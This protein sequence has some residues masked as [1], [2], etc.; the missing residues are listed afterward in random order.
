M[1]NKIKIK[2]SNTEKQNTIIDYKL[3]N[4]KNKIFDIYKM[5]SIPFS[6]RDNLTAKNVL[7]QFR[8]GNKLIV[9]FY[10]DINGRVRERKI[11]FDSRLHLDLMRQG[12]LS[13]EGT[14]FLRREG[15]LYDR[16]KYKTNKSFED[17]KFYGDDLGVN[18]AKLDKTI[19]YTKM[20]KFNNFVNW[21][22]NCKTKNLREFYYCINKANE[23]KANG[24]GYITLYF[25]YLDGSEGK[26]QYKSKNIRGIT[27][28]TDYLD[29][30]NL[31]I[32]RILEIRKG[33]VAGSDMM[34]DNALELM[35]D[36]FDVKYIEG[37]VE[38]REECLFEVVGM[39]LK[40]DKKNLSLKSCGI[41]TFN[42]LYY[43]K[44][45]TDGDS[46]DNIDKYN[47]LDKMKYQLNIN[48]I[49]VRI[50]GNT[51]KI[52]KQ[53]FDKIK[54]SKADINING[55]LKGRRWKI[56]N[57]MFQETE[58][59]LE[60]Y[61]D[62]KPEFT[63]IYDSVNKH[64]DVIKG[65]SIMTNK[66]YN[67]ILK[68][69]V[70]IDRKRNIYLS[71]IT[72]DGKIKMKKILTPSQSIE[73]AFKIKKAKHKFIF[74]DYETI[75]DF[76]ELSV[77]KPY[78][79]SIFVCDQQEMDELD[80][81]DFEG[82]K[83]SVQEIIKNNCDNFV[84]FDCS[85]KLFNYIRQ[86]QEDTIF[87]LVSFNGAN[88]DNF[89]LA[90][91]LYKNQMES[92]SNVCY[93]NNQ[94]L[95]FK[96]NRRHNTFD[97]A[98][99]L[100]GSLKKNCK[101]FKIKC[102]SKKD[103]DHNEI[104]SIYENDK[105]G[106]INKMKQNEEM[107]IYNNYD[108]VSLAVLYNRY[109]K[110]FG[111]S[112]YTQHIDL[113]QKL[114]IGSII[115]EVFDKYNSNKNLPKLDYEDYKAIL[116]HK[117]AGRVELFNGVQKIE[118]RLSSYDV[119]SL[120]PFICSVYKCYFPVG[121]VIK[122]SWNEFNDFRNQEGDNVKIIKAFEEE[123][124]EFEQYEI[125]EW[126][127]MKK[128]KGQ[129]WDDIK[130][131]IINIERGDTSFTDKKTRYTITFDKKTTPNKNH[132]GFFWVNVNQSNLIKKNLPLIYAKKIYDKRG[133]L[134]KNDW[135]N[136][137]LENVFLSSVI[138]DAL[139]KYGCDVE[140]IDKKGLYFSGVVKNY[141]LFGFLRDFMK[142]KNDQD[143][144]RDTPEY[145]SALRETLKLLM[146]AIS[147]K[148]IEGLHYDKIKLVNEYDY[149]KI[150]NDKK[151]SKINTIDMKGNKIFISYSID[152]EELIKKQRP[153]YLGALIYDYAKMYM[154]NHIYSKIGLENL[155]YTD[156]DAG[157]CRDKHGQ[158]WI[159][160]YAGKKEMKDL[161]WSDIYD[162]DERY[163]THKLYEKGSKVFGSF[164]NELTDKNIRSYVLMKKTYM[165]INHD[166]TLDAFHFK[167]VS[168]SNIYLTGKE[169]FIE[170]KKIKHKDGSIENKYIIKSQLGA[171]DFYYKSNDVLVK[172]ETR[173]I[174]GKDKKVMVNVKGEQVFK[175]ILN[176]GYALVL[177]M[178]FRK[179]FKNTRQNVGIDD[180]DKFNKMNSNIKQVFQIKKLRLC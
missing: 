166:G 62:K 160:K 30:H 28:D 21:R 157:K 73:N 3:N 145:N 107:I 74:F 91:Y 90:E 58:G 8:E 106:F 24:D 126:I 104:Q 40:T 89:L 111:N 128:E 180:D 133:N 13:T 168:K 54:K 118:E 163:K 53:T 72:E 132:I 114:T 165:I 26:Y 4:Q 50:I 98:K 125:E 33:E 66:I 1:N 65:D 108:V 71:S 161:I 56:S 18:G 172:Y 20:D 43:L 154:Y 7:N 138:I 75:T 32:E 141:E 16:A 80:K 159:N 81:A 22:V 86:N 129:L 55:T 37:V 162:Y 169:D 69:N 146:N 143:K 77:L 45:G 177:S 36:V 142:G 144:L 117:I 68:D 176:N 131:D 170:I 15:R 105:K 49:R 38:G 61:T 121:E 127:Y 82:D 88:F 31:F 136:G 120:Y 5:S 96:I 23:E 102:C 60:I 11:K 46:F 119:C 140:F 9:I 14:R 64:I 130:E 178:N 41:D 110:T 47:T 116:E 109:S 35:L 34:N 135:K 44:Y 103:L 99:H 164:E 59:A 155:V 175:D 147:G 179:S 93:T 152:E 25:N 112:K 83:K 97:I 87:T 17:E 167:G 48:G 137:K 158:E 42:Y 149:H 173:K 12:I 171:R 153:V 19:T 84:G 92:I 150:K 134:L 151:T 51:F 95:N 78:S 139:I 85:E 94:L 29:S 79:L 123:E 70:Y 63:L 101:S 174:K 67:P 39:G 27:I 148:V 6:L 124:G 52:H 76:D 115:W 57:S 113:K 10:D 156:T 100:V 122:S 2:S